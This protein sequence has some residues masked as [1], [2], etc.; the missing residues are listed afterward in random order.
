M[1]GVLVTI[2]KVVHMISM[3][4][5]LVATAFTM[6]MFLNSVLCVNIGGTHVIPYVYYA[7]QHMAPK[8]LRTDLCHCRCIVRNRRF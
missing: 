5:S 8:A 7:G 1:Q 6:L 3:L 4:N 2:V